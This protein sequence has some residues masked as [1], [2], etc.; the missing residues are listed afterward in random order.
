MTFEYNRVLKTLFLEKNLHRPVM[1][2]YFQR[3]KYNIVQSAGAVEYDCF[4][5]EG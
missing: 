2:K 4:S 5:V 1:S 3:L